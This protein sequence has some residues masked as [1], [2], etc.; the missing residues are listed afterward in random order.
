[1]SNIPLNHHYVSQCQIQNFFNKEQGKIYLYDKVLHNLFEKETTKSVF[2]ERE[3]NTRFVEGKLDHSSLESD[4]NT[5]FES[6][7]N[8]HMGVI[9]D[10]ATKRVVT[11]ELND[12]VIHM[13]KYGIAGA[14]RTPTHKQNVDDAIQNALCTIL[15]PDSTPE[16]QRQYAGIKA[17]FDRTKHTNNTV[18]SE[19]AEGVFSDMGDINFLICVIDCD[20]FFLLPDMPSMTERRRI[21]D[22]FNPE[23]KNIA[24]VAVPLSSKIFMHVQ[25]TKLGPMS[26]GFLF[27]NESHVAYIND[28]NRGLFVGATKQVAC[29]NKEYLEKAVELFSGQ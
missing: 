10:V 24:M 19:F 14:L 5:H 25:S 26:S 6:D 11:P 20:H 9:N 1:M 18:Y 29:E 21:I 8:R 3:G 23:A 22:H 7:Y 15:A 2:S 17:L 16:S 12:A 13:T 27:L 28:V 4:L